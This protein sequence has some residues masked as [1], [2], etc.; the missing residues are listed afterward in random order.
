MATVK[1][2]GAEIALA[3]DSEKKGSEPR[4]RRIAVPL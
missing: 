4:G 1:N 2:R 3:C